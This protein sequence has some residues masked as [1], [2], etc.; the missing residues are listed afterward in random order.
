MGICGIDM[1]DDAKC[2]DELVWEY[3]LSNYAQPAFR[4]F[5]KKTHET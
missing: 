2:K 1:K 5:I 4:V 3:Y